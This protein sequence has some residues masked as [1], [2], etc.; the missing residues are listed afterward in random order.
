MDAK[1]L[2]AAVGIRLVCPGR[3]EDTQFFHIYASDCMSDILNHVDDSTL[4]VTN[5]SNSALVRVIELMDVP[6]ICLLNSI[7]PEEKMVSAAA[8]HG[9]ALFVSPEG[10]FETCGRLYKVCEHGNTPRDQQCSL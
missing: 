2:A 6:G 5:L 3:P 8:H 9:A 4:L 1:S 10:M 7:E